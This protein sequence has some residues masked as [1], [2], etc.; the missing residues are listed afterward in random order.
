MLLPDHRHRIVGVRSADSR[1]NLPHVLTSDDI[2]EIESLPSELVV[3]GGGVIGVEF[4]SFFSMV[5]VKV[6]VIEMLDEILPMADAEFGKLARRAMKDVTFN[7]GC[8]VEKITEKSV[9][10]TDA[11]GERKELAAEKILMSVGRRPNIG[12]LEALG[13]KIEKGAVV[14]DEQMRTSLPTVYAI[15]DVNGKSLLPTVRAG[16]PMWPFRRSSARE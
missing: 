3:I 9:V 10:Y 8:K 5:G 1:A 16:W 15:G 2:L 13:L 11:K 4:A 7:L 6:T 14:V 12:G